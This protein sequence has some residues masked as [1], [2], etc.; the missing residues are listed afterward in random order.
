[1]KWEQWHLLLHREDLTQPQL[2]QNCSLIA[3]N[4]REEQEATKHTVQQGNAHCPSNELSLW[5]RFEADH[6]LSHEIRS[7]EEVVTV[8]LQH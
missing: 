1:M 7:V 5:Q 6:E 2:L 8:T 3:I 4:N